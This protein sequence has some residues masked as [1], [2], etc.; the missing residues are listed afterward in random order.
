[1]PAVDPTQRLMSALEPYFSAH[2]AKA[3]LGVTFRRANV[4]PARVDLPSIPCVVH[5]LERAL[6]SYLADEGRRSE[7]VSGLRRLLALAPP[8]APSGSSTEKGHGMAADPLAASTAVQIRTAED[9]M[10][11]CD[12][13]RDIARRV[14][15]SHVDQTKIATT[16]SELARNILLYA[17]TGEIRI[18]SLAAPA[19]SVEVTAIDEGPGIADIP[20]VMSSR[21]RSPT[22]MGMGL[23][24]SKK[25]MDAF[26]VRSSPGVGTTVVARKVLP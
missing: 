16:V 24:G 10:N 9:V 7:C 2:V 20:L 23:K 25:L 17:E 3:L 26:E 18:A 12:A 11:A 13:A 14:G 21:Y 5:A 15:F 8:P 6:P 22:G 1:M 19:R 4:N